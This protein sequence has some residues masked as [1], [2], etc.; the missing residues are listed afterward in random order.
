[1][2]EK[3]TFSPLTGQIRRWQESK[4][5]REGVHSFQ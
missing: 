4:D 5:E 1:M 3:G 2:E